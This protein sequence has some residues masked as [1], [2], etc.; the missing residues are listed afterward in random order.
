MRGKRM[1]TFTIRSDNDVVRLATYDSGDLEIDR[2]TSERELARLASKWPATRLVEIWNRIPGVRR[3]VKFKDRTTAVRRVWTKVQELPLVQ[4]KSPVVREGTKAA[5][6]IELL[7]EP[8]GATLK[9]IMA[10]TGW[11]AHSIRGFI[12]V[13]L[14]KKLGLRV[15]SFTRA[16]ERVYRIRR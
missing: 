5:V 7:R 6:I 4:T 11:Q 3:V 2:F 14:I 12:S 1:Y 16:G 8:S 15:E 9:A 10:T 13:Q